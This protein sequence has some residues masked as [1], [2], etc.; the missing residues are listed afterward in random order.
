MYVEIT[1]QKKKN[2]SFK[3]IKKDGS[4]V[5]TQYLCLKDLDGKLGQNWQ[6]SKFGLQKMT[7]GRMGIAGFVSCLQIIHYKSFNKY[8]VSLPEDACIHMKSESL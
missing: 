8:I 5:T 6:T 7:S 3:H 4:H 1:L 2:Q